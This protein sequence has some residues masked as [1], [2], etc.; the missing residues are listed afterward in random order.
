MYGN[1]SYDMP[2]G[3]A[4]S[5]SSNKEAFKT[6]LSMSNE[7]QDNVVNH[8]KEMKTKRELQLMVDELAKKYNTKNSDMG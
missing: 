8:A 5:L 3:L 2:I 4:M 7:E 1:A 6:F